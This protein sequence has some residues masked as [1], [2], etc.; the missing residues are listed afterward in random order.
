MFLSELAAFQSFS[1]IAHQRL[2]AK[3][4]AQSFAACIELLKEALRV[5]ARKVICPEN[6][7]L[8]CIRMDFVRQPLFGDGKLLLQCV[9]NTFADVAEGSNIVGVDRD[10]YR[11]HGCF[12]RQ[13]R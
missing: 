6:A 13:S 7:G 4:D 1:G 5:H 10:V 2:G 3:P 11:S 12:P 8:R 9:D